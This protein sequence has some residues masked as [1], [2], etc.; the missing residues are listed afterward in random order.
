MNF[1]TNEAVTMYIVE[2]TFAEGLK[3][4]FVE[5]DD[6]ATA[7]KEAKAAYK[8]FGK[9]TKAARARSLSSRTVD[10]MIEKGGFDMT[11]LRQPRIATRENRKALGALVGM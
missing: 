9:P 6:R 3:L 8:K 11:D 10:A 7:M 2:A 1:Q 5:T 4:F